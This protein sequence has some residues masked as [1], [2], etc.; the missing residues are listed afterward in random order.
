[1]LSIT[2]PES[3]ISYAYKKK[4]VCGHLSQLQTKETL[5]YDDSGRG[6]G[7]LKSSECRHMGRRSWPN[8][9]I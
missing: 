2:E 4:I 7:L 1:L 5:S 8:C 6:G 9:H 3:E